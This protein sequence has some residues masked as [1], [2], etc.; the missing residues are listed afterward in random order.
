MTVKRSSR[1]GYWGGLAIGILLVWAVFQYS[2]LS[3]D[4][5]LHSLVKLSLVEYGI[6][7]FLYGLIIWLSS[8]RWSLIVRQV[9]GQ[10]SFVSG[11][12]FYNIAL[13]Q[14][15]RL[16][17]LGHVA[18]FGAKLASLKIDGGTSLGRGL[19]CGVTEALFNL[20]AIACMTLSG[21]IL[22][23]M[24]GATILSTVVIAACVSAACILFV[25]RFGFFLRIILVVLGWLSRIAGRFPRLAVPLEGFREKV[26]CIVLEPGMAARMLAYT[27]CFYVLGLVRC[28]FL[29]W[30]MGLEVSAVDFFAFYPV[31]LAVSLLGM[32]PSGL[33]LVEL[34]W[35]GLLMHLGVP[36]EEA[37]GFA[38]VRRV[39]DESS[40]LLLTLLGLAV[41]KWGGT[42]ARGRAIKV[43]AKEK[44]YETT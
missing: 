21:V 32:T 10:T 38:V 1:M 2:S 15:A 23:L 36:K 24:D 25:A 18:G 20:F 27:L 9:S 11:F 26:G 44:L 3:L 8:R 33:G 12:F 17:P 29:V 19:C 34:G 13:S 28:L 35:T 43:E 41:F 42:T 16:M 7:I 40:L 22:V 31:M 39:V 5:L 6:L 30:F 4:G 14:T 37:A